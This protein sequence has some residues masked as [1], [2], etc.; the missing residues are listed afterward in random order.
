MNKAIAN[1]WIT[2]DQRNRYRYEL[3]A[4]GYAVGRLINPA[5]RLV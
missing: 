5:T 2:I 1:N 3:T 4:T